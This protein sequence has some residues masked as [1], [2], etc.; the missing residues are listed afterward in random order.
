METIVGHCP[1][2][3]APIWQA[4][5]T[6]SIGPAPIRYSCRCMERIK[7]PD[8][9]A[10]RVRRAM[11][12]PAMV[13]FVAILALTGCAH[14][15]PVYRYHYETPLPERSVSYRSCAEDVAVGEVCVT[16]ALTVDQRRQD[17]MYLG[18]DPAR[19]LR[20]H[21]VLMVRLP[22]KVTR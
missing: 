18:L 9:L 4:V 1:A 21:M 8:S 14:A 7:G 15:E 11:A 13:S 6:F 3:G 19:C 20:E 22:A 10:A 2:C 17:R 12:G 5:L 16:C